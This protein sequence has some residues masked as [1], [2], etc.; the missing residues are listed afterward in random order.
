MAL[1][2]CRA[3]VCVFF[4]LVDICFLIEW[5][6]TLKWNASNIRFVQI[7]ALGNT[8]GQREVQKQIYRKRQKERQT[9]TQTDT[10]RQRQKEI[11]TKTQTQTSAGTDTA[12]KKE[13]KECTQTKT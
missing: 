1:S 12:G 11:E 2:I 5:F 7:I 8:E 13:K 6:N 9:W 3:I 10:S 4:A